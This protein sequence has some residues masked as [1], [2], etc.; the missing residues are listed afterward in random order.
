MQALQIRAHHQTIN[1]LERM[2]QEAERE[3]EYRVSRR[4]MGLLLNIQGHTAGEISR[5]LRVHRSSATLW[6]QRWME[7]GFESLLEGYRSGRPA[8]L[9]EKEQAIL[10]DVLE[11][12]PVAYGFTSGV[13]TSPMIAQ[14]IAEEFGVQYHPGH[15]RKLLHAMGFS[16]QRPRRKL[17]R[18]D[19][20]K[21]SR[22]RR[23]TLPQLKKTPKGKG[24]KSSTKTKRAPAKSP[25]STARGPR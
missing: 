3:G 9:S 22:W 8:K 4:I 1:K 2:R 16:V 11:S 12:G 10:Y 5:L 24:P 17:A 20:K 14:V 23:Y 25:R 7:Y 19:A 18:A 15:V 6:I 13:W 21:Q